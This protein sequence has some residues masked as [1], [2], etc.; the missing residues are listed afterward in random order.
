M[1]GRL[2]VGFGVSLS[3]TAECIY[4]SEIAPAVSMLHLVMDSIHSD[5]DE[6]KVPFSFPILF[7]KVFTLFYCYFISKNKEK[8]MRD[9]RKQEGK[10]RK[11]E[12]EKGRQKRMKKESK[13][14][15]R[16]RK[17]EWEIR[18]SKEERKNEIN[19]GRQK[20]MREERK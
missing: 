17:K 7:K 18:E 10:E 19:K 14:E 4:I 6:E 8:R 5:N 20:G 3:A 2:I 15:K 12:I 13:K 16:K 11:K 9:W 1:L